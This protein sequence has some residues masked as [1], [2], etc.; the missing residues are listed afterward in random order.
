MWR[1]RGSGPV[2]SSHSRCSASSVTGRR[3]EPSSWSRFGRVAPWAFAT[4]IGM[5]VLQA[6]QLV[7]YWN[8][9]VDTAYGR[10]LVVKIAG[11]VAMIGLSMIALRRRP[12]VRAEA[13]LAVAVVLAAA[14][15][16]VVAGRAQRGTRGG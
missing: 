3:P 2:A 4:S 16:D 10:I 6:T 15:A 13:L 12:V 5:G 8:G 9:L 14:A 1:R 11:V 7:G